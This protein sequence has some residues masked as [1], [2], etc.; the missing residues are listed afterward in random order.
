M[1]QLQALQRQVGGR[2]TRE[3]LAATAKA[4]EQLLKAQATPE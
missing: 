3:P 2:A 1:L 4:G